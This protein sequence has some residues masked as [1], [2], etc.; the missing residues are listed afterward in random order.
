M[1][2]PYS[3]FSFITTHL[4]YKLITVK[5]PK[6]ETCKT[7]RNTI[8]PFLIIRI[9]SMLILHSIIRIFTWITF[10]P[11]ITKTFTNPLSM[12]H[13]QRSELKTQLLPNDLS[14]PPILLFL[15]DPDSSRSLI[16]PAFQRS[17]LHN[18]REQH[19]SKGLRMQHKSARVLQNLLH[20]IIYG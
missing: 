19:R 14:P 2:T 4:A 5:Y 11:N 15:G 8:Q 16:P 12:S 7:F 18:A 9:Q 10:F 6:S 20:F 17:Y 3:V 13:A 1:T